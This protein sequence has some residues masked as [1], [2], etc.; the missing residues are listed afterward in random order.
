MDL[1]VGITWIVCPMSFIMI[2]G[3]LR[4]NQILTDFVISWGPI[5]GIFLLGKT[6]TQETDYW[7][8]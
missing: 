2:N 1:K 7:G 5:K 4:K 3:F 8:M 6:K